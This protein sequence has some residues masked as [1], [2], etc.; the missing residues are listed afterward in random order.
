MFKIDRYETALQGMARSRSRRGDVAAAIL[1]LPLSLIKRLTLAH[2]ADARETMILC[3]KLLLLPKFSDEEVERCVEDAGWKPSGDRVTGAMGKTGY[4]T[5]KT[6]F[7]CP[8]MEE[9]CVEFQ[10][11]MDDWFRSPA[12]DTLKKLFRGELAKLKQCVKNDWPSLAPTCESHCAHKRAWT[13]VFGTFFP[14]LRTLQITFLAEAATSLRTQ[15][16]DR[17]L[18]NLRKQASAQQSVATTQTESRAPATQMDV[19]MSHRSMLRLA[20]AN[21]TDVR[22][23]DDCA[24][25]ADDL[26]REVKAVNAR[27]DKQGR[28]IRML[29]HTIQKLKNDR[30]TMAKIN[31]SLVCDLHGLQVTCEES[32]QML[33]DANF[34]CKSLELQLEQ[35]KSDLDAEVQANSAAMTE[36][37]AAFD[38]L[39]T[40]LNSIGQKRPRYERFDVQCSDVKVNMIE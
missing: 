13:H 36:F 25:L 19:L 3:Y 39:Q 28:E 17:A 8:T 21:A 31:G 16:A 40:G 12:K 35:A 34:K 22:G 18:A 26:R 5:V 2:D 32:A 30:D 6:C 14:G 1:D 27:M 24:Q 4:G 29:R 33:T 9:T 38:A 7:P 15:Q 10:S 37:Q 11:R 23:A 20:A